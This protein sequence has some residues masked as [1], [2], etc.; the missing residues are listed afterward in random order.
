MN[1]LKTTENIRTI[2]MRNINRIKINYWSVENNL[3]LQTQ[4]DV[5]LLLFVC[6]VTSQYVW[7]KEVFMQHSMNL[8]HCFI[9]RREDNFLFD[10]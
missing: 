2:E 8:H 1:Y 6:D 7:I 10:R 9:W 3:W 4:G 5:T